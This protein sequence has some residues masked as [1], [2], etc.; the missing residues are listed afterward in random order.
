MSTSNKVPHKC[1]V[2]DGYGVRPETGQECMAC[3]GTGVVWETLDSGEPL[4]TPSQPSIHTPYVKW[5]PLKDIPPGVYAY[6]AQF[7]TTDCDTSSY[8][9]T[10]GFPFYNANK[11][12]DPNK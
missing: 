2:C 11:D 6:M 3:L 7:P 10:T 5:S 1:P 4:I 9:S 8:I 12:V